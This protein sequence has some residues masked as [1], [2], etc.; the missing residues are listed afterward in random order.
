MNSKE[1]GSLVRSNIGVLGIRC[2]MIDKIDSF[3]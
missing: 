2:K 1:V 3:F